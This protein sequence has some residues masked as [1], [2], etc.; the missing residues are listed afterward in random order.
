[1]P[2]TIIKPNPGPRDRGIRYYRPKPYLFVK[3]LVAKDGTAVDGMVT[4]EM[5]TLPDFSEEYSI[6]IRSGFGINE[7]KVTL[8]DGWNLTSIN[9]DVDSQVDENLTAVSDLVGNI[10]KLTGEVNTQSMN[11]KASNVPM[12]LYEAVVSRDGHGIKRLYGFRYVGFLPYAS[13]PTTLHG[14]DCESCVTASIYGL[15]FENGSM[16]FR[17]LQH[18]PTH[19]EPASAS[20]ST[21][22]NSIHEQ[23]LPHPV[24][25]EVDDGFDP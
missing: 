15:V 14:Q 5:T 17:E 11:C 13:C 23:R 25:V 1:L 21:P 6:H 18:L 20:P 9:V 12:G 7:T 10:P 24:N 19:I 8:E 22:P 16:V 4:L 3:P 2:R